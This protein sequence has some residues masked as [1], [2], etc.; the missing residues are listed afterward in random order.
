MRTEGP[1]HRSGAGPGGGH[2]GEQARARHRP[3]GPLCARFLQGVKASEQQPAISD[4]AEK[5]AVQA[6]G[7]TARDI[8]E[9]EGGPRHGLARRGA[10]VTG[11]GLPGAGLPGAAAHRSRLP[12]APPSPPTCTIPGPD[13]GGSTRRQPCSRRHLPTPRQRRTRG[14]DPGGPRDARPERGARTPTRPS[15]P[16]RVG[17]SS[18]RGRVP[19]ST[20]GEQRTPPPTLAGAGLG[21]GAQRGTGPDVRAE[22]SPPDGAWCLHSAP[23]AP[24]A[25]APP[26]GLRPR[27]KGPRAREPCRKA[28]SGRRDASRGRFSPPHGSH[29]GVSL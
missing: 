7:W 12:R 28:P 3:A 29:Q 19:S 5:A 21:V 17:A 8:S 22:P 27:D 10:L 23:A 6:S 25:P 15:S 20:R 16:A 4:V 18:S 9:A 2:R 14:R 24:A 11:T 26:L 1:A 13:E